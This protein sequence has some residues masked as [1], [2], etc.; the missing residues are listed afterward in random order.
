MLVN[1]GQQTYANC[2]ANRL[3][4]AAL[5][6]GPEPGLAGMQTNAHRFRQGEMYSPHDLTIEEM[7]KRRMERRKNFR[8]IFDVLGVN[9]VDEYK[10]CSN[11]RR[12]LPQLKLNIILEFQPVG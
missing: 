11:G 7:K 9:P 1:T 6:N 3:R 5:I 12:I 4:D 8:D 10:V 2:S